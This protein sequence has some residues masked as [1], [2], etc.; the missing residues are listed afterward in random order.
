MEEMEVIFIRDN[1][2]MLNHEGKRTDLVK[3]DINLDNYTLMNA[4]FSKQAFSEKKI[5]EVISQLFN[6]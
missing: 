2:R 6:I 1:K 4:E 5:S 3:H